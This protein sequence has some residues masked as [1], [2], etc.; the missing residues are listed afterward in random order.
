MTPRDERERFATEKTCPVCAY[1]ESYSWSRLISHYWLMHCNFAAVRCLC[2]W[3]P[4]G[5][6]IQDHIHQHGGLHLHHTDAMMGV[7]TER[8]GD[9]A[10]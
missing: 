9:N 8:T 10:T 7:V 2:G 3:S 6:T 5:W 1:V 4:D